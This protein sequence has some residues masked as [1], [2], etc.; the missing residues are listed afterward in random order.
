MFFTD[1]GLL[2][3]FTEMPDTAECEKCETSETGG[4]LRKEEATCKGS[5]H[6]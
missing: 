4:Q 2:K 3:E 6:E 1:H 5:A